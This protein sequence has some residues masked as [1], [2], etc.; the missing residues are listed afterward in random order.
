MIKL[1]KLVLLLLLLWF[2]HTAYALQLSLG[3]ATPR[4]A[5]LAAARP[6]QV[7]STLV[8]LCYQAVSP[9]QFSPAPTAVKLQSLAAAVA[10]AAASD[11]MQAWQP[12]PLQVQVEVAQRQRQLPGR[13]SKQAE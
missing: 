5:L 8:I 11:S 4:R 7:S 10:A 3:T 13:D 2:E 1:L 6:L 9:T 12:P